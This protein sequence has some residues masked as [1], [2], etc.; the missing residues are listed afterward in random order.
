MHCSVFLQWQFSGSGYFG[1]RLAHHRLDCDQRSE[2]G[3]PICA[4]LVS[5]R[6]ARQRAALSQTPPQAQFENNPM[7]SAGSNSVSTEGP[8]AVALDSG[9]PVQQR[10]WRINK[11]R[12]TQN[13]WWSER[14]E[15][16]QVKNKFEREDR[17]PTA[18]VRCPLK[19][20]DCYL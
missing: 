11:V 17:P 15:D 13:G 9:R 3:Y 8:Q 18:S 10:G 20:E 4:D 16:R 6:A 19:E 7:H 14:R 12:S 5:G 2:R 1:V